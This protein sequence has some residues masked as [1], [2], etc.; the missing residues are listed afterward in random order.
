MRSNLQYLKGLELTDDVFGEAC[1]SNTQLKRYVN[2]GKLPKDNSQIR[3]L[4]QGFKHTIGKY[5][6]GMGWLDRIYAHLIKNCDGLGGEFDTPLK[7]VHETS[8]RNE[9]IKR[10]GMSFDLF[11]SMEGVVELYKER[12]EQIQNIENELYSL[13]KKIERRIQKKVNSAD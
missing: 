13:D 4:R 8:L 7:Y 1:D 10:P 9:F 5:D 3:E 6:E 11:K 12:E 2:S